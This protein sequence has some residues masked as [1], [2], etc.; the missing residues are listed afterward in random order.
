MSSTVYFSS[1]N[2]KN[3]SSPLNKIKKLMNRCDVQNLYNKDEITAIKV[4]FGELGNTAFIRPIFLRPV[5]ETLSKIGAK[6]FLTDTNTLYVG[7]RTNSVD[8]LHNAH[9][10]GFGY[11]TLQTPIIIGDGMRGE[12]TSKYPIEKGELR[13]EAH[14]ADTIMNADKL[15]VMSHF[16][17]HEMTGFGGAVKNIAMGCA[18]RTGKMDMHSGVKPSVN[19][20]KCTACGRCKI[21]CD[22][23]AITISG[24]AVINDNCVGCARCIA[25][26]PEAAISCDFDT[27]CDVLQQMIV[28][29]ASAVHNH[30]SATP[31][32][33]NLLTSIVP[34]C[35]CHNGND[36]PMVRDLG[37]MAS[38]DPVA[39]DKA[40]YDMVLK[41]AG[42]DVFKEAWHYLDPTDQFRHAEK[43]GF[44]STKYELVTID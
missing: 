25:M 20:H 19:A 40:S 24:T 37:F 44:G 15:F 1:M 8:H 11:G 31:I 22:A 6:P 36:A 32:Y 18:S 41:E 14:L 23:N 38:T 34:A 16:K 4:H 43:I 29:Y 9:L 21:H 10:N 13:K 39:L 33:I 27:S 3:H 17:G 12:A 28:E 7:M 30:Y 35:D 5:I 42:K 2:T 26:C